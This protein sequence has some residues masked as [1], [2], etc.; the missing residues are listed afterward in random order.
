M[1]ETPKKGIN[2]FKPHR[3]FK[4]NDFNSRKNG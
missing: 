3:M 2:L 1:E 4:S